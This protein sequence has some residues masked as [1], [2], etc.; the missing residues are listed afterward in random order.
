MK[1]PDRAIPIYN[2]DFRTDAS[3]CQDLESG[4]ASVSVHSCEQAKAGYGSG[5]LDLPTFCGCSGVEP[6]NH[7][8]FCS[9]EDMVNPKYDLSEI[10][11]YDLTCEGAAGLAPSILADSVMCN[12][13]FHLIRK[14][15]CQERHRC[16]M[17]SDGTDE[18]TF[19]DKVM[20]FDHRPQNCADFRFTLGFLD[21]EECTELRST[22]PIDYASYCGC[23]GA[24]SPKECSL[25]GQRLEVLYDRPQDG[26]ND[27]DI[28]CEEME[29]LID[30]LI[31]PRLCAELQ[32]SIGAKCCSTK[33]ARSGS[34][35]NEDDGN[36]I[37]SEFPVDH[38][39]GTSEGHSQAGLSGHLLGMLMVPIILI[40]LIP[41]LE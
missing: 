25:C 5:T 6:S 7:C 10:A 9:P 40:N 30:H 33:D 35:L 36:T 41:P 3:T 11:G 38:S 22:F 19:P 2:G 18:I 24:S 20:S 17:C 16:H 1:N 32:A 21:E 27:E 34:V 4:L 28:T 31:D 12:D 23:L 37:S 26:L 13:R 14:G 29:D 8:A 39:Q 15:C